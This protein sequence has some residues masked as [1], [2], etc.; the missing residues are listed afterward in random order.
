MIISRRRVRF[1]W[2]SLLNCVGRLGKKFNVGTLAFNSSTNVK[3]YPYRVREILDASLPTDPLVDSSPLPTLDVAIPCTIKDLPLLESVVRAAVECSRNPIDE[4]NVIVPATHMNTFAE[5]VASRLQ[6]SFNL[7]LKNEELLL[8]KFLDVC[9]LVAPPSRRGWLIQQ[10][11]KYLAVIHSNRQGVLVI[12]S[13]TVLSRK[14]TWLAPDGKQLV[15]MSFEYHAPYQ[16]H[17]NRFRNIINP[18]SRPVNPRVSFVTHHQLMQS[19][20]LT[21]MLGGE[22]LWQH[23]LETWIRSADFQEKSP[24]CEYHCY[25]TYLT[26]TTN[27]GSFARW[28]NRALSRRDCDLT[29]LDNIQIRDFTK[30]GINSVS[31][32]SY[33]L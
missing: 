30:Q 27:Y 24:L 3:P 20:F 12:D 26:T 13:D 33:L 11:A 21:E 28:G 15:M 17:Y 5:Y 16:L 1:I 19:N 8:G 7:Q 14:R 22:A 10:V 23:G 29:V 18:Q 32:H 2:R 4:I 25:G 6:P 31:Q 9:E